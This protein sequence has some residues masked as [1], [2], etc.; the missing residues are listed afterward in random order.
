M[1]FHFNFK[2]FKHSS[3]VSILYANRYVTLAVSFT[4]IY[5]FS[6]L[7]LTCR[8]FKNKSLCSGWW[9]RVRRCSTKFFHS[10]SKSTN[11]HF[12]WLLSKTTALKLYKSEFFCVSFWFSL[13][14]RTCNNSLYRYNNVK[15]NLCF[16][17]IISIVL[18]IVMNSWLRNRWIVLTIFLFLISSEIWPTTRLH[19]KRSYDESN[20]I[21]YIPRRYRRVI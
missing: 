13:L 19:E 10:R 15:E 17:I 5:L 18:L 2:L 7:Y 14:W 11:C 4:G 12:W 21:L 6:R 1:N 9:S 8:L 16:E 3:S 20:R